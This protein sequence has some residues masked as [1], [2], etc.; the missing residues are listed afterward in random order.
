MINL[1]QYSALRVGMILFVVVVMTGVFAFSYSPGSYKVPAG[2]LVDHPL[3]AMSVSPYEIYRLLQ[4]DD[5]GVHIV[6]IRPYEA[7]Q[8]YHFPGAVHIPADSILERKH[9]RSLRGNRNLIVGDQ[10]WQAHYVAQLLIQ[11]GIEA[12]A[13][14]AGVGY[15]RQHVLEDF[16]HAGLFFRF[17][18]KAYDY[19]RFIPSRKTIEIEEKSL[20]IQDLGGC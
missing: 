6:D 3:F 12:V 9:L 10:E 5:A 4:D 11:L 19:H 18:K 15:I 17:E 1:E 2:K 20:N 8:E 16:N 7:F 13:V 14:N